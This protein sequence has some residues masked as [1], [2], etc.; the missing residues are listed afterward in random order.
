MIRKLT[1]AFALL[2]VAG[3]ASAA[4]SSGGGGG[5]YIGPRLGA[6]S[7]PD[8]F[9]FGGQIEFP[10]IVPRLTVVPD[11]EVGFGDNTTTLQVSA[12]FLY[13]FTIRNSS[14]VP[15][16]GAGPTIAFE[17]FDLPPGVTGDNSETDAGLN[18]VVG[19]AVPT[20]SASRFFGELKF[21]LGD[22]PSFK[23][24]VGWAFPM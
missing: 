24:M 14:W 20:K 2:L 19:A 21:G 16:A 23:A 17:S 1:I 9:V 22:I 8:Q 6:S 10:P 5:T 18:L 3:A 4:T 7:S 13:H 12:D 11:L 15:Y